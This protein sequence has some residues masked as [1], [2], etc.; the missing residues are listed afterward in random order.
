MLQAETDIFI[1]DFKGTIVRTYKTGSGESEFT[2]NDLGLKNG[3]YLV[4]IKSGGLD[5]GFKKLIISKI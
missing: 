3:I 2:I 4:R 5:W 1:Y